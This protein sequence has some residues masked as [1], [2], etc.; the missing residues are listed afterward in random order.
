MTPRQNLLSLYRRHGLETAPV[1]FN[2]CPHLERQFHER[3]PDTA[4]YAEHFQFPMRLVTD[5]GFPWIAESPGFVPR[6]DG[7]TTCILTHPL[8]PAPAWT[9]GALPTSRAARRPST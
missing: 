6:A 5:P 8:P 1:C 4:D 3:Y 9:F 2:L 7:I